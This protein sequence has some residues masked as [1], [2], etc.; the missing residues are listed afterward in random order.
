MSRLSH[1]PELETLKDALADTRWDFRTADGLATDLD[2]APDTVVQALDE[3]P[4]IAR[5]SVLTDRDGRGLYTDRNRPLTLRERIE[6]FR[7]VL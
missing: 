4:E 6:R 2:A 7:S 1:K 3:H 5:K